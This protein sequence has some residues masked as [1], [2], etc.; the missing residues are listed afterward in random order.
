MRTRQAHS[1]IKRRGAALLT[2]LF[3]MSVTSVIV[4]G[5]LETGTTQLAALKNTIDYDR[6]RYL[7]EAG[8]QHAFALLETDIDWRG[9]ISRTEFPAGSGEFY[10][11]SATSGDNGTVVVEATGE[12]G[13]FSRTVRVVIKQGG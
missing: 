5:I 4:I 2:T 3:V 11:A 7:A 13:S 6:S 10:Q 9:G 8:M 1:T 12:S